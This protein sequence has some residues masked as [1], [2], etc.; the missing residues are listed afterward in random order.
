ME[1]Q[2]YLSIGGGYG[3]QVMLP[4]AGVTAYGPFAGDDEAT[5]WAAANNLPTDCY[6]IHPFGSVVKEKE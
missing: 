2:R 6:T 5:A 1:L 4:L 3:E